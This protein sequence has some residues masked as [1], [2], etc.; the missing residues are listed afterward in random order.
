M[1]GAQKA[2]LEALVKRALTAEEYMVIDSLL[3]ARNDLAITEVINRGA[4]PVVKSVPVE[5]V[6][7]V[8]FASGDYL[9]LKAAQMAGNPSAN[10]AFS[11]LADSKT[12]GP[13]MVNLRAPATV[14]LLDTLQAQ[15]LLSLAGRSALDACA[16]VAAEPLHCN[17]ISDA[18][19]ALEA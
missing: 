8:L 1:T 12:I 5:V 2:A 16:V 11:V 9:T 6:F 7:N 14:Q 4:E 19:N 18:L 13:G 15:E 10:M 3:P 17:A